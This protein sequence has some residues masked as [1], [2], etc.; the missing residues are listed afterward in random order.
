MN[1]TSTSGQKL[2][3]PCASYHGPTSNRTAQFVLLSEAGRDARR[4]GT[5]GD[6]PA[7]VGLG[8]QFTTLPSAFVVAVKVGFWA[9]VFEDGLERSVSVTGRLAAGVPVRVFSTWH[10]IGSRDI[11]VDCDCV[12]PV[13]RCE[14]EVVAAAAVDLDDEE[15]ARWFW[16]KPRRSVTLPSWSLDRD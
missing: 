4:A 7:V 5:L 6:E 14:M 11:G 13:C 1:L 12:V 10:V 9:V 3:T 16:Y 2:S 15:E 8:L